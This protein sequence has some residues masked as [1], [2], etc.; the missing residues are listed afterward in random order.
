MPIQ[1]ETPKEIIEALKKS[2][3]SEDKK[4]IVQYVSRDFF[5]D[6][7][8]SGQRNINFNEDSQDAKILQTLLV[9]LGFLKVEQ[10][11]GILDSDTMNAVKSFA[12]SFEITFETNQSV[13]KSI[14]NLFTDYRISTNVQNIIQQ[15]NSNLPKEAFEDKYNWP[16]QPPN[17]SHL[18]QSL[19]EKL[20]GKIEY[21]PRGSGDG[22]IITNN[23]ER[24]NIITITIPQLA[25]IQ[26]PRSTSQKCH[27]LAANNIIALWQEWENQGL[28]SRI[29][30]FNGL[31][32]PRFVRGS[33]TSLSPHAFGAAFDINTKYN[34]LFKTPP[35]VDEKGSVRELVPSA[36]KLG[37]FWGGY[38]K[39]RKDGMHFE[40]INPM[41]SQSIA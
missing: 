32:N 14:I 25:K 17:T 21:T 7:L 31:Y 27:R 10:M 40:V 37:F 4:S 9:G 1:L 29:I 34:G 28:L 38:Y 6:E 30:T 19:A 2:T 23:F 20:Y 39:K 8:L 16:P 24:D 13:S 11:S 22:I 12:K 15:T 33:K 41:G 35:A 18:S 5:S 36:L 3:T 26:H